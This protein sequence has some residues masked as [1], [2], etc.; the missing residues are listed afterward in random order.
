VPPWLRALAGVVLSVLLLAWVLRDV[1]LTEVARQIRGADPFLLGAA[2]VVSM[3]G[4][5]YR[6]Q[7]WRILLRPVNVD[8]PFHAAFGATMIGFAANNLLPARVGELARAYALGRSGA[9]S[10]SAALGALVLERLLDGVVLLAL[11][12]AVMAAPG[13]PLT[14]GIDPRG[15]A[16]L[17]LLVFTGALVA[18]RLAISRPRWLVRAAER[19]SR[20]LLPLPLRM[21]ARLAR[22][23]GA[24]IEGTAAMRDPRLF[25]I[26]AVWAV[27]QWVFLAFSFLLAFLAFGIHEPGFQGAIFLQSLVSLAAAVPSSPGFFGP[28]EAAAR[29]GLEVWN[30]PAE[31]A[32]SFAIGFHLAGFVPVSVVGLIYAWQMGMGVGEVRRAGEE[33]TDLQPPEE[34]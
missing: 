29:L 33:V 3:G 25:A 19:A 14:T 8:V 27:G 11:L 31:Q 10:S 32:V 18:L 23:M 26:S 7:R 34:A 16:L 12:F 6:A 24:F 1:S 9:V 28:F 2:I 20:L 30:I 15:A 22:V 5:L 13:F 21:R 4:F 17:A